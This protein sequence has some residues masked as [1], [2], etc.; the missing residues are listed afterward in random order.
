MNL[1]GEKKRIAKTE[2]EKRKIQMADLARL[3]GVST[4]TVSRALNGSALINQ[5]TRL[6]IIDLA[7]SLDYTINLSAQDALR[8]HLGRQRLNFD[9]IVVAS[10]LIAISAMGILREWGCSIAEDV[11]VMGYDY[12][13]P[14]AYS[15]SPLTTVRQPLDLAAPPSCGL[16]AV[17]HGR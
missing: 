14:A 16:P 15:S 11:S 1:N 6:R 4:A 17:H 10:D 8:A 3:A 5:E 9:A 12:V 2:P 13:E 7:R